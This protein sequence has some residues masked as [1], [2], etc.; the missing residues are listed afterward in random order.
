[1][2][3]PGRPPLPTYV[4]MGPITTFWSS[5]ADVG[6]LRGGDGQEL[7]I[8]V[9]GEAGHVEH[10]GGDVLGV[11]GGLGRQRTIGLRDAVAHLR[12]HVGSGVSYVDL[13]ARDVEGPPVEGDGL[14]QAGDRVFGRGVGG[15]AGAGDVRGYRAIVD[16]PPAA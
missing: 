11:E 8:G 9:K 7:D 4:V 10:R 3:L 5:T 2:R 1:M 13:A 12:G 14:G 6:H 16:D 15:T